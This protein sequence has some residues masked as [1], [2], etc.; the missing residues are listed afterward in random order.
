MRLRTSTGA[1]AAS[2]LLS[3]AL[4]LGGAACVEP[5]PFPYGGVYLQQIP[6][7]VEL[8]IDAGQRVELEPGSGVGVAVEYT[9]DGRWS[10]T[11][12][13][14]TAL[15]DESCTFDVLVSSD[16]SSAGITG[17]E[18]AELEAS[19]ALYAP[20]AFALKLEVVTDDDR[21]GVSFVTSPGATVRVSALLYDPTVDSRFDW[22][23]DPRIISWVGRGAAHFGAPT[24]PIDLT[25]DRP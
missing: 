12:V 23:D 1:A 13:C 15:S 11:T 17:L 19:D 7:V 6:G 8:A 5:D 25:P 22:S 21:D 16:G 3:A 20:D 10:L 14:D 9:G 18:G 2:G 4:L 24:N